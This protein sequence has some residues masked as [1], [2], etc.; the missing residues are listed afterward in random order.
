LFVK[1][2]KFQTKA[3]VG[4]NDIY[5][6]MLPIMTN[7]DSIS[8]PVLPTSSSIFCRQVSELVSDINIET[9]KLDNI[10]RDLRQYYA[11]TKTKRQFGLDVP[12]GFR[13][14]S[15]VSKQF[16]SYT[17][18]RKSSK[19]LPTTDTDHLITQTLHEIDPTSDD[20]SILEKTSPITNQSSIPVHIPII[21]SVDKPSSS[22]PQNISMTEDHLRAC[23]GFRRVESIKKHFNEL[24]Q[25]TLRLDN[26]PADAILDSGCFATLWKK[27]RN[28]T[29]VPRPKNFGD[30]F[31]I[32]II[33]GPEISVGN[34]HY[35][36]ICVDRYSRMTYIY[37]LKNLTSDIQ[38][39]LELFFSHIG[40]LQ[41]RIITDFDLKLI[42]GKARK[43]LNS[44]LTHVNAA[45]SYRQDKNGLAERH[46]QTLVSM[47]R[48]WLA[49]AEL[50][51][52]FWFYAVR[53]AAE[54]CNYF[55]F[56]LEDNSITTP[57]ELAHLS[58]PDLRTLFRP[59]CLAA[60]RRERI[61]DEV[62]SKFDSQSIPMITLGRCP[63]SDGLQ[64]FN[65][66]NGSIVTSIDCIFQSNV[67]S[68]ARF[69]YKY[70]S[71]MFL[72]RLDETNNIYAP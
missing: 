66:E 32:D 22:L 14:D 17:P 49:S 4:D 48:N 62:L 70:Q 72:Y 39:Q 24:Y 50:P 8:D 65:P 63:N 41:H 58:K 27:N 29:P 67:T 57:F 51:A 71:G 45:P 56:K 21:R 40:V 43:Y 54:V 61:G 11:T 53:R 46:W 9:V 5:L 64:F 7:H 36:L 42:G 44:L 6:D 16:K 23:L 55:P 19:D 31:H 28:T 33:F 25:N 59:F 35:G 1:F 10:L 15:S 37:P 3:I 26:T 68:G 38:K 47:S 20:T 12:A 13:R 30:V 18:P 60:I 69:G 52:S 34:V 2:P